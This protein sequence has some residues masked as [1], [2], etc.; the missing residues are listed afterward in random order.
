LCSNHCANAE[1]HQRGNRNSDWEKSIHSNIILIN[2]Y[3]TLAAFCIC[4]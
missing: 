3:P 1:R 2:G 4:G